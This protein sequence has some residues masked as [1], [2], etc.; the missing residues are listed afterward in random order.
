L[1]LPS[2]ILAGRRPLCRC[3]RLDLAPHPVRPGPRHLPLS[4]RRRWCV[5]LSPFL[6]TSIDP[7][8]SRLLLFSSPD[9]VA[10]NPIANAALGGALKS[11]LALAINSSANKCPTVEHGTAICSRTCDFTAS[12]F[13]FRFPTLRSPTE[14]TCSLALL[15]FPQCNKGYT[16]SG[17][18]CVPNTPAPSPTP[19]VNLGRRSRSALARGK[20]ICSRRAGFEMCPIAGRNDAFDCVDTRSGLETCGGES[21]VWILLPH[22]PHLAHR[23][24]S[25]DSLSSVRSSSSGCPQAYPSLLFFNSPSGFTSSASIGT[26]CSAIPNVDSVSC[27]RGSCLV[28]S[29]LN[30]FKLSDDRSSCIPDPFYRRV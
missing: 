7:E 1:M 15:S 18:V 4:E 9:L 21:S 22:L 10:Q 14:L 17:S 11:R 12:P 13:L 8:L 2:F 26:D 25:T 16:K 6:L 27:S 24:S 28:E 30:G 19:T 20:E 29:C 23:D 3:V 5:L